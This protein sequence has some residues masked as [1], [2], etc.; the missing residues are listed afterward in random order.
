MSDVRIIT[1]PIT[2]WIGEKTPPYRRTGSP[3]K[4]LTS[5]TLA[6]LEREVGHLGARRVVV[7]LAITEGDVRNDGLP[8]ANARPSHPGVVVSFESEHGPLR[9]AVDRFETWQDNLRAIVLGLE[10]LR[11]VDRYGMS[12]DGQQYRG[13]VALEASTA[14]SRGEELIREHGGVTEALKA[15]HPDHGGSREDFDAVMAAKK[16]M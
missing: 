7:E 11:R 5:A 12:S 8:R 16:A 9:Y 3:F 14:S 6:Q 1:R 13:W 2:G 4:S 15:T 10:S